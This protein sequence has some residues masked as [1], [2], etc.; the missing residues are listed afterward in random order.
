MKLDKEFFM[1]AIKVVLAIALINILLDLTSSFL[2]LNLAGF[3]YHPLRALGIVKA[4]T[5]TTTPSAPASGS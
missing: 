1:F 5:T 4:P 3:V 2:G